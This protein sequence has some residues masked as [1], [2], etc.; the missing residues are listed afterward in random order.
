MSLEDSKQIDDDGRLHQELFTEECR[1]IDYY[2][3]PQR[4]S[5]NHAMQNGNLDRHEVLKIEDRVQ[6]HTGFRY[7]R[8]D[9]TRNY[10]RSQE[11]GRGTHQQSIHHVR[12]WNS[13][14]SIEEYSEGSTL[15]NPCKEIELRNNHGALP[16]RREVPHAH[17]RTSILG[18]RH[19][20]L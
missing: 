11:A 10:R 2:T 7:Q 20:R 14:I 12:P 18:I 8:P 19:G 17:A 9:S 3:V 6:C 1:K 15:W 5:E 4:D 16:R 13:Q